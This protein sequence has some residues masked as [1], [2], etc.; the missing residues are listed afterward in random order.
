MSETL[1]LIDGHAQI[2]RAYYAIRGGM[3]SAVTGEPTHAVFGFTGMLLKLL[4][5]FHP[6]YVVVA[7]DVSAPTFRDDL[8]D[9]YKGTRNAVPDD[10]SAQVPRILEVVELFGLPV[11][12]HAGLEADD[13]IATITQRILDDQKCQ[14]INIRIVSKDKDLEQLLSDRVTMFDIH[15]DTTIDVAWLQANKGI[16]PEQVIDTLALTGDTVDNVPGVEGIGL[17]TAA[18]LIQQFGSIDGIFANLEQVKGKRRENLEKARTHLPLSRQLVTLIR[19]ADFA[20]SLEA[21][22]VRPLQTGK[23]ISLFQQL[24][25]NRYQD[26]VRRLD[27]SPQPPLRN[28]DGEADSYAPETTTLEIVHKTLPLTPPLRNGEG[29]GGRGSTY[30]SITTSAQLEE[31]VNTLR[32]QPIISVDTETTGLGNDS[33]LCGLSFSWQTGHGVYVPTL[34][35]QPQLHLDETTVLAALK[36]LL[37]DESL[38][39]CGHNLKFDAGVLLRSGVHLRGVVFDSMLA[40][41]LIDPTSPAHKLDYLA[42]SLLHYEMTPIAQLIGDGEKQISMDQVPLEQVVPYAAE[43]TDIALR[44]YHQMLPQLQEMGMSALMHDVEAPLEPVLAEMEA[45]G[46]ICDPDELLRQGDVLNERVQELRAQVQ[47][48]VGHEFDLNSPKQLAEVLFDKLGLKAGKKTKTGRSTD[49]QEL[50]RLAALEDADN[51]RSS[52]PRLIIEYRQLTKLISTYL[53]NL[54][55]AV[56]KRSGRIHTTF[57]QLVTATGRLA[58]HNPNL[59]NIPVRSNVGRQI[60]QAFLAAPGHL[61][62]CADYSQIELRLLAHLS[63]DAALVA[64]FE[65]NQDIHTAVAA[66]VFNTPLDQVTKEQR[67]KAKTINFGIIYGITP[68]GLARRIEGLDVGGAGELIADYR[69]RFPGL[70]GFLQRCV[71]EALEQGYVSTIMGRRRA[72]PEITSPN[73]STRSLGERLAINSVVQGSAAD[74]IKLAMVNVQRRID[75]DQ[76]PMKLLLQIHDELVLEAPEAIAR[77]QAA[78]VCQEMERAMPLRVPLQAECGVGKNWLEAK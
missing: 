21:A 26:E 45:N 14:D 62:I 61:L 56:D 68:F 55:A 46:I 31:L 63:G 29:G 43:D 27:L 41:I 36:P 10:L 12:G 52:V 53:G 66:Q 69:R 28:G 58:S 3:R 33:R 42:Q 44:L 25:F 32:S 20:F 6:H 17:K 4:S 64:A 37:E 59:Q 54:R 35:P 51:P 65:Q 2:F 30:E 67:A 5:Q 78:I 74:L 18:Q 38:A 73:A 50:E 75:R 40:S 39:K 1:Y 16:T 23:I 60:R 57:H 47:E 11:I 13:V 48:L 76:L 34:S 71:H 8:F 9:Q 7:I 22:R 15:T 77:E 70:D 24:G 49:I 72:I 19:D